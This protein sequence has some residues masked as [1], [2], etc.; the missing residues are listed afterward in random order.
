MVGKSNNL[1]TTCPC[2]SKFD[3]QLIMSFKKGDFMSTQYNDLPYRTKL[4][5]TKVIKLGRDD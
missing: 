4:I 2:E 5:R 1:P 3:I